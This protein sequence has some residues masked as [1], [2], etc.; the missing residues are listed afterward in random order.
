MHSRTELVYRLPGKFGTFRALA[1]IDDR[2]RP[3]GDVRLVIYGDGR[4]LLDKQI[5]GRDEP[6]PLTVDISGVARLK[7]VADF[8]GDLD[9]SDHLDLCEP[10]VFK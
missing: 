2:V 4:L 8:G 3:G 1:G 7:I 5:T 6:V 10:R 9:V